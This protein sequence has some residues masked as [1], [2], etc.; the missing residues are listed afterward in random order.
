MHETGI[1]RDLVRRLEQAAREAGAERVSGVVVWLG[2]LSQFSP[3]HFREHFDDE[4][5]GTLAEGAALRIVASED[6]VHPQAQHVV[7]QSADF[8]VPDEDG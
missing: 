1:V 4:A 3:A 2:A 8:A 5:R 7:L 6:P